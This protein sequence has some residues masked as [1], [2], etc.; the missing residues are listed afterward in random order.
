MDAKTSSLMSK[1]ST[2]KN[3]FQSK[4]NSI[5]FMAIK[6]NLVCMTILIKLI[7]LIHHPCLLYVKRECIKH[8]V[9]CVENSH[10]HHQL[11]L[12]N[13]HGKLPRC[14]QAYKI[15]S[16]LIPI[17]KHK[18]RRTTWRKRLTSHTK[19]IHSNVTYL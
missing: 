15:I 3:N 4:L 17:D 11:R 6:K 7:Y 5:P 1:P 8:L 2:S 19:C 10:H 16:A 18:T 12:K 13:L 14:Y 9:E